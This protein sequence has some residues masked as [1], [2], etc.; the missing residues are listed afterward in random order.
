MTDRRAYFAEYYQKNKPT[1]EERFIMREA[2]R[3]QR[4]RWNLTSR[5]N[6]RNK[7]ESV[8]AAKKILDELK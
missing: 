8:A 7:K 2:Y 3:E 1:K 6:L 4:K 5:I